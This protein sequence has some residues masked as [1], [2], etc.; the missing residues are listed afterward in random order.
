M[1]LTQD[2]Y[3]QP[4]L[5]VAKD[6]IGKDLIHNY[7][8]KIYRAMII[9]TEAYDGF[10][11]L[12][13]HAAKGMTERNK[14]MFRPGGCAYVY[15]IY[16]IHHCLNLVTEKENYPAAVLIRGLD[17]PKADGPAKLCREFKISKQ[18]HNGIDL[19][20]NVLWVEDKGIKLKINSGKR[21]GIDYAKESKNWPWR[22]YAEK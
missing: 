9:E 15:L 2:F 6:L 22:F 4:T 18:A 13:S 21:V 20:G 12:A 19:I 16:G 3:L 8:G 11:D 1:K 17:Y 5:K 14:I 10:N 7:H